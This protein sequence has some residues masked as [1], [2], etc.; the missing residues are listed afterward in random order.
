MSASYHNPQGLTDPGEGWYFKFNGDNVIEGDEF[1][2]PLS[3]E[4]QKSW[5]YPGK[6]SG[7]TYRTR[8]NPVSGTLAIRRSCPCPVAVQVANK[9]LD[10]ADHGYKKYGAT[11]DRGDLTLRQWAI[12]LQEELM[13]ATDYIQVLINKMGELEKET[14]Q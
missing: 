3:N 10:R 14:G 7:Y 13:D 8:I 12:H 6:M 5:N 2:H 11:L 9:I 1:F 4:W